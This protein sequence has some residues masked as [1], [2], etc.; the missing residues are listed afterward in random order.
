V[1]GAAEIDK[2]SRPSIVAGSDVV[3]EIRTIPDPRPVPLRR[4]FELPFD[5]RPSDP[6]GLSVY[7]PVLSVYLLGHGVV[8]RGDLPFIQTWSA[9][10]SDPTSVKHRSLS[11]TR[12]NSPR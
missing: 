2:P 11:L 4:V 9:A 5:T 1:P 7:P 3:V 12:G 10:D 8:A 6:L